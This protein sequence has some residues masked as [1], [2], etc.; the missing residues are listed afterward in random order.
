MTSLFASN[1]KEIWLASQSIG[2][3]SQL[4][5]E[6]CVGTDVEARLSRKKNRKTLLAKKRTK[7]HPCP[8]AHMLPAVEGCIRNGAIDGI[9]RQVLIVGRG[10]DKNAPRLQNGENAFD[11]AAKRRIAQVLDDLT[12]K[13]RIKGLIKIKNLLNRMD[14]AVIAVRA[15]PPIGIVA[16]RDFASHADVASI[17]DGFEQKAGTAAKIQHAPAARNE[18]TRAAYNIATGTI[19]EVGFR[20]P[21][22][23]GPEAGNTLIRPL[24][25]RRH[26]GSSP[27]FLLPVPKHQWYTPSQIQPKDVFGNETR[28]L[29]R[30]RARLNDGHIRWIGWFQDR[31]DFDAFLGALFCGSLAAEREL[32]RLP[33][34]AWHPDIGIEFTYD[35]ATV[36]F[37]TSPTGSNQTYTSPADWNNSNNSVEVVAAGGSGGAASGASGGAFRSSSG[38]GGGAYSKNT[39]F[40]FAN[41]GTTTA[42][43]RIGTGGAAVTASGTSVT[44]GNTG[45]DSWFNG[46]TL[47]GST[48]GAQGG[49]G[50]GTS[51]AGNVN[52]GAGGAAASGTGTTKKSGGR[53]GNYTGGG[54]SGAR[55]TGGGGAAGSTNDGNTGVDKSDTSD[56]GTAGGSADGGSGGAGGAAGNNN[57]G[58]GTEWDAS[59]GSGGGGGGNAATSGTLTGGSGGNYGGGGG[60]ACCNNGTGSQTSGAGI[61]GIIM[62]SYTPAITMPLVDL[63]SIIRVRHDMVAH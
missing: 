33:T 2:G 1:N 43:Y 25:R 7:A 63:P 16:R 22:V 15:K 9:G 48:I 46:T 60:G 17:Y 4:I 49:V 21:P 23:V 40:S 39:N 27:R 58:N 45:G 3:P 26:I 59:H 32:W 28:T 37:L 44:N 18:A 10:Q 56:A 11:R 12:G 29:F 8:T 24:Q 52:G 41:P 19:A 57:G 38:A 42:T 51:G 55:S 35:F 20:K 5:H 6:P 14:A 30:V 13:D 53:G 31:D 62:L 34:P 61:Q 36:T 50:G 54:G 47:G